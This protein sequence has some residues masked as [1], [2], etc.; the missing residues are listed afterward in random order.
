MMVGNFFHHFAAYFSYQ[1]HLDLEQDG[2]QIVNLIARL[3]FTILS[4]FNCAI[5]SCF[6]GTYCGRFFFNGRSKHDSE[7][8]VHHKK[9]PSSKQGE[10]PYNICWCGNLEVVILNVA[11][12]SFKSGK[13]I[14][15][16]ARIASNGS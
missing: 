6:F 8:V 12:C 2:V 7:R 1:S 14:H 9:P 4:S 10:Q 11:L 16:F 13:P 5:V 3:N 15:L